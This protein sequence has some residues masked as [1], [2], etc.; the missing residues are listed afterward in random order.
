M[1]A[2]NTCFHVFTC[3]RGRTSVKSCHSGIQH[4]CHTSKYPHRY[5]AM[6][7]VTPGILKATFPRDLH[8]ECIFAMGRKLGLLRISKSKALHTTNYL[9]FHGTRVD[10]SIVRHTKI[11]HGSRE[12]N[13]CNRRGCI[14]QL[15]RNKH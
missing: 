11:C 7:Q 4:Q 12:K 8:F 2:K 10:V 14:T 13:G 6:I 15:I 3:S 5:N 9:R 1:Y